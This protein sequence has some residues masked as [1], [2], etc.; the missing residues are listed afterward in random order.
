MRYLFKETHQTF[1]KNIRFYL[2][3]QQEVIKKYLLKTIY[4]IPFFIFLSAYAFSQEESNDPIPCFDLNEITIVNGYNFKSPE[5]RKEYQ[6]L[7]KDIR[8]IYP[9]LIFIESEYSRVNKELEYYN[10]KN[11][12]DFLKW[13]E[14]YAK[15][16]YL[17][18]LYG[19][20]ASQIQLLLELIDRDI[21]STPYQLI[22][23]YR[24]GFRAFFWQS[25][26]FLFK[27]NLN[28]KYSAKDN[29]MIEHIMTKLKSEYNISNEVGNES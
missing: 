4:L 28:K 11:R 15:K 25:A 20:S 1:L 5:E 16:N 21:Q 18:R 29:P 6:R 9:V 3:K 23:T 27:T 19:L 13:Y 17:P 14:K 2:L 12:K 22:K 26:A 8:K 10:K 24:N 7:E